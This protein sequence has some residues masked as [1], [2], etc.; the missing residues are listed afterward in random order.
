MGALLAVGHVVARGRFVAAKR[1]VTSVSFGVHT[2]TIFNST[3]ID[4]FLTC[5][6]AG[7]SSS[8]GGECADLVSPRVSLSRSPLKPPEFFTVLATS[9]F[10]QN[11]SVSARRQRVCTLGFTASGRG[12]RR[13][14]LPS[15]SRGTPARNWGCRLCRASKWPMPGHSQTGRIPIRRS[16]GISCCLSP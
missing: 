7:C 15:P 8:H 1:T 10:Q 11:P 6:Q 14:P 4:P 5:A 12:G 3:S 16:P 13:N 2:G 9:V